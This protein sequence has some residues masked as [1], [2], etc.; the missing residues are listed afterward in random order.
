MGFYSSRKKEKNF[1][2]Y[3]LSGKNVGW[4]AIGLSI[5][6]TNISSEHFIGL[7]GSGATRGLAVAQFELMA[8]FILILLGWFIAPIYLKSGAA[9]VPEIIEKRFDERSRKFLSGLSIA[10]YIITKITVTLLAGGILFYKIFGLSIYTSAIIIVLITG[11]YSVIGGAT[12]VVKTQVIQALLLIVGAVTLTIFGLYEVGGYSGLHDKLPAE[13]FTMFKSAS[14]PDFPWTGIIFGAP[15][16]AFWYWCTDQYIVQRLLGAKS[17]EEARR[18]SLFAALLKI[19]PLFILVLP[20]LIAIALFPGIIGDEAYPVLLAS[21]ILPVGIKGLVVAGLLS[22][23][24]SSLSGVFNTTSTLFV[25]DFY[26][27]NHKTASDRK[28]VLIGRLSTTVIV[29][30]AI[31]CVPLVKIISTQMYLFLQSVQGFISP[32]ITAVFVFGLLFKKVN[33]KAAFWTLIIGEAIGL[34]R[35]LSDLL[36]NIGYTTNSFLVAYSNINFLHFAILLFVISSVLLFSISYSTEEGRTSKLSGLQYSLKESF[37]EFMI[38]FPAFNRM[39]SYRTNLSNVWIYTS[40][41][42]W[43]LEFMELKYLNSILFK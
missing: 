28:L 39:R 41:N 6:A 18:G 36:V 13:Y 23:I 10:I 24:M 16:I 29:I 40:I 25:N 20:G 32:P 4:F 11:V 31:L 27:P 12:A 5:F 37:S 1:S 38:A 43:C 15:I 21:N 14:D 34:T 42:F 22:A 17:I 9:T 35:L 26:L 3:F 2:D 19:L 33:S 30:T 8:I 7:A